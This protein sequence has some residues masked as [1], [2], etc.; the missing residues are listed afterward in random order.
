MFESIIT[1]VK[2]VF[3]TIF[4]TIT[5]ATGEKVK[6]SFWFCPEVA[7]GDLFEL[8]TEGFI[9]TNTT[10]KAEVANRLMIGTFGAKFNPL[11]STVNMVDNMGKLLDNIQ[12]ENFPIITVLIDIIDEEKAARKAADGSYD[13]S[14]ALGRDSHGYRLWESLLDR[15]VPLVVNGQEYYFLCQSAA[16]SKIG[17]RKAFF[18]KAE[19]LTEAMEILRCG[20]NMD[21]FIEEKGFIKPFFYDGLGFTGLT[22]V[23][24]YK[25]MEY[26]W[27][28]TVVVPDCTVIH[29]ATPLWVY[30]PSS[31]KKRLITTEQVV[32]DGCFLGSEDFFA[33]LQAH[34]LK[35]D[36]FQGRAQN[37]I[38]GLCAKVKTFGEGLIED[39]WGKSWDLSE[40]EVVI[41]A[42]VFKGWMG[43]SSMDDY[44]SNEPT[45]GFM[46]PSANKRLTNGQILDT[47]LMTDSE[48]TMLAE[49][50]ITK[51]FGVLRTEEVFN[52][53]AL[54]QGLKCLA[55][56]GMEPAYLEDMVMEQPE[57]AAE[58]IM[59]TVAAWKNGRVREINTLHYDRPK[60][61]NQYL[62]PDLSF[63]LSWYKGNATKSLHAKGEVV[64]GKVLELDQVCCLDLP[65]GIV[66]L[67][68]NPISSSAEL[69]IAQ[70]VHH[71]EWGI[72]GAVH[73]PADSDV[74]EIMGGA[75]FDGDQVL[76]SA[77][78]Y[79]IKKVNRVP[80]GIL[81]G[82]TKPKAKL[83]NAA[84]AS[85]NEMQ[86]ATFQQAS[87]LVARILCRSN[88]SAHTPK[89]AFLKSVFCTACVSLGVDAGKYGYELPEEWVRFIAQFLKKLWKLPGWKFTKNTSRAIEQVAAQLTMQ[90]LGEEIT[91]EMLYD[92]ILQRFDLVVDSKGNL[93]DPHAVIEESTTKFQKW[94]KKVLTKILP[95]II[96][97]YVNVWEI[98]GDYPCEE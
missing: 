78:E 36:L 37:T 8:T 17:K 30:G 28:H 31:I 64:N 89:W 2:M 54:F 65:E 14:K 59:D 29:T 62:V 81:V 33:F 83:H 61:R 51:L 90:H 18:V 70:N 7:L 3:A 69:V 48:K 24:T 82:Y 6:P 34:G 15:R 85:W 5:I 11:K 80:H 95:H 72:P 67:A 16:H 9:P 19:Y 96:D 94:D 58:L 71:K 53:K 27:E 22:K 76:V 55:M 60:T 57:R 47:L 41:P 92:E 93:C 63:V 25:E 1:F 32:N 42:S 66:L 73:V 98:Y 23:F 21:K 68:R 12:V 74:A 13:T 35:G 77:D 49:R 91:K 45:F 10:V 97:E 20:I 43:Y 88:W 38:K 46:Q 75:D 56:Q 52:A 87:Q 39:V 84:E 4:A 40:V 44:L 79:L 50:S 26:F 86:N